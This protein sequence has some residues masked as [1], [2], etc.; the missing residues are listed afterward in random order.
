[1]V[2]ATI[3][4]IFGPGRSAEMTYY[5]TKRGAKVFDAGTINFGRAAASRPLLDNLRAR[6]SRP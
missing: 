6:L 4:D 5:E 2:L 3:P 1:M